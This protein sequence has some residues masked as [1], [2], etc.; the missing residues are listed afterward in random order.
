MLR[1]QCTKGSSNRQIAV[2]RELRKH[3]QITREQLLNEEGREL[4]VRRM[5]EVESMFGH[6]KANRG[7]RRFRLG[8]LFK[9]P[10]EMELI[11]LAHNLMKKAALSAW[12]E[13]PF[14]TEC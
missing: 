14:R 6:L 3:K 2:S 5:V 9:T 13:L 1:S 10:I 4:S 11:C 7:F 8:G 12:E